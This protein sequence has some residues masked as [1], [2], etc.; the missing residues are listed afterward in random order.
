MLKFRFEPQY[1]ISSPAVQFV[2]DAQRQSPVHP[3]CRFHCPHPGILSLPLTLVSPQ[4]VYS[5]G[6]VRLARSD[7][8]EVQT[9][10]LSDLRFYP[11][12]RV[13]SC[14]QRHRRLRD[15][16]EHASFLQGMCVCLPLALAISLSC[17]VAHDMHSLRTEEGTVRNFFI[18]RP[19]ISPVMPTNSDDR[20]DSQ[21]TG[22]RSIC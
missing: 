13:V 10:V 15:A 20:R 17:R 16:A 18:C 6:H 5:N 22:Q 19:S 11:W 14:A 9:N 3:V 2:V 1:P 8:R 4:H 12:K 21:T 7:L